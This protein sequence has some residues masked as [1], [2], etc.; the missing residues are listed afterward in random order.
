M[1]P[2]PTPDPFEAR[3]FA[4]M[5]FYESEPFDSPDYIYELKMDGIRALAYLDTDKITIINKRGKDVTAN[6]PELSSIH[7]GCR[8]RAVIDGEIVAFWNGKPDFFRLQRRSLLVDPF[9][10]K[11]AAAAVPVTFVAFDIL[12]RQGETLYD[13]PLMERKRMLAETITENNRLVLSRYIEDKG[14]G[15]FELAKKENLEGIVAKKKDSRYYPGTRRDVW[16]KIKVY[17]EEDLVICGYVPKENGNIKELIMGDYE[18]GKLRIR[19]RINTMK[20]QKT[21]KK[22]ASVFPGPPLASGHGEEVVWMNPYL[23]GT[24]RYMMKTETGGLRQPVF[25]G[26]ST[27]KIAEDLREN[28]EIQKQE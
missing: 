18:N 13:L 23:V 2:R 14:I 3:S 19:L 28:N 9:K 7:A 17:Q 12:Y 20:N 4:P 16:L 27:D 11:L 1:E 26:I 10:I 15:F 21:I 8:G 24:V 25:K 22:F 5:L 6:Y